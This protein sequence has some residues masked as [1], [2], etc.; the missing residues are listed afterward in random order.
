MRAIYT[1]LFTGFAALLM[2]QPANDECANAINIPSIEEYCSGTTEF[3]TTDAT[4][5]T[6]YGIPVL[7]FPV[8]KE[9]QET[10]AFR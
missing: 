9:Q 6:G 10:I 7:S 4:T 8:Y 1:L 3:T 5:S 2:A